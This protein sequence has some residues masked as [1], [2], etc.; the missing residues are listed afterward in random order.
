MV[1]IHEISSG[2]SNNDGPTR[3]LVEPEE[4]IGKPTDSTATSI[5]G[6]KSM[7]ALA[8]GMAS[9]LGIP[10]GDGGAA[11]RT[12]PNIF[13]GDGSFGA[14]EDAAA[15]DVGAQSLISLVKSI[16]VEAGL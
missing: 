13:E 2:V 4:T 8:R 7:F 12:S 6:E 9:N 1:G 14:P 15:E 3:T 5:S 11:V 16:L 10:A